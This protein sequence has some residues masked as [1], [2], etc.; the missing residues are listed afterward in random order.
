MTPTIL[1]TPEE[2]FENLPGYDFSPNYVDDLPGYLGI[3]VH[4]LDEGVLDAETVALCLH[5]NPTWSYLYRKMIP[6]FAA[7]GMR[8]IAPDLIG[9]GRSDKPTDDATY[10]YEFHRNMLLALVERLNLRNVMLVCQDWG[11]L[12]GLTLPMETPDRYTRLFVMNTALAV[13]K[14]LSEGFLQ[15]R[16]YSNSKPDLD[17]AALMKRSAPN[18]S[19]EELAAYAA[20]F[21]GVEYKAAI[22]AFPNLAP[23]NELATAALISQKA[24]KWWKEEWNGRSFMAIGMRDVVIPPKAMYGLARIIRNC[25]EPLELSDIG[26]FVQEAGEPLARAGLNS[27]L[28]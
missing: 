20:P 12:F 9:T 28:A 8:V 23:D 21:P 17:I 25:P 18:L 7:A 14:P 5:G 1:R 2:R 10:T 16:A 22:R 26:H 15:W 24:A 3:R 11:G 6:V 4:Y 19:E 13:G 27:L